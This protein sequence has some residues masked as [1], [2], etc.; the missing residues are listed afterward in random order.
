MKQ[1]N[2]KSGWQPQAGSELLR[3]GLISFKITQ[4]RSEIKGF[5]VGGCHTAGA[6]RGDPSALSHAG[7]AAV[8]P[9]HRVK[10]CQSRASPQEDT[11]SKCAEPEVLRG[12]M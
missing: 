2:H 7:S 12:C 3:P 4:P 11:E 10:T 8:L 5:I 1:T 6:T 9:H